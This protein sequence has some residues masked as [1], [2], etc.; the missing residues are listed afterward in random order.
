MGS[1]VRLS[2]QPT[3]L[4]CCNYIYG[5][6]EKNMTPKMGLRPT[7]AYV[8][9]PQPSHLPLAAAVS[10][11]TAAAAQE[12]DDPQA[13]VIAASAAV[14]AAAASEA[15]AAAQEKD[16]PQAAVSSK[17]ASAS[18]AGTYTRVTSASAV[19]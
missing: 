11:E 13:A 15:A 19:C 10:S 18:T 3:C 4:K 2:I 8:H 16:D 7:D 9:R 14:V 5:E 17:S 1:G 12:K 6:K